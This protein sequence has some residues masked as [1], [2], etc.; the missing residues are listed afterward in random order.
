MGVAHIFC[1]SNEVGNLGEKA[2]TTDLH[3]S[4]LQNKCMNETYDC[5]YCGLVIMLCGCYVSGFF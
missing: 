1:S 2:I 5:T 3:V 4:Y